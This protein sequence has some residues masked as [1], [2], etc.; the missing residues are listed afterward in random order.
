MSTRTDPAAASPTAIESL[1]TENRSF[2]PPESFMVHAHVKGEAEA[3]AL[4]SAA[5]S[6]PD[7]FWLEQARA[8]V[9]H[10]PP[11]QGLDDSGHP[12][13]RWFADGE[14]NLTETCLDQH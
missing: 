4:R 9:W 1:M 5:R 14:L 13:V 3:E 7:A 8:L 2:P 12:F 6:D 10:R 11:T